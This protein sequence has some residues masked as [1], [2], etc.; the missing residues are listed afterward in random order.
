MSNDVG[1]YCIC[2]R[3]VAVWRGI[4]GVGNANTR[5]DK[6]AIRANFAYG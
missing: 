1:R 3:S 4:A 6:H 5:D 2:N